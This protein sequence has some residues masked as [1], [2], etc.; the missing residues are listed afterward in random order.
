MMKYVLL[1]LNS[2]LLVITAS[3]PVVA[4]SYT[5]DT[6]SQRQRYLLLIDELR[7]PKCQNQNLSDSDAAIAADL[8]HEL[9]RLLL[10]GKTNQEIIDFMVDRYG[11]FILYRPRLHTKTWLLW[12]TPALLMLLGVI[13]LVNILSR[14]R[15]IVAE[16]LTER[17]QIQLQQ[18][19]TDNEIK[20]DRNDTIIPNQR[21]GQA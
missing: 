7:C 1:I 9:R 3:A 17:E 4:D 11:D 18:L 5:F 10:E 2:W 19:L 6:E 16:S 20:T 13:V 12:F 15:K 8:R 14:R 21:R